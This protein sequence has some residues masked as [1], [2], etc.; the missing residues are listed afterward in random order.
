MTHSLG[1][2]TSAC[3]AQNCNNNGMLSGTCNWVQS[4]SSHK[5]ISRFC[6][7]ANSCPAGQ[8]HIWQAKVADRTRGTRC[9]YCSNRRVCSHNS[10]AT[11]APDVARYWN[12]SKNEK[13]PELVL[14]GSSAK[15]EWKCPACKLEWQAPIMMRTRHRSGCPKCSCA[16]KVIQSQPTFL[17]AQPAYLAE[18]D[19]ELNDADDIYPDNTTLGSGKQVHWICSC[20]PRGQPHRWT[21][22]PGRRIGSGSGCAVCAGMQ[23]CVCNSLESLFPVIAAEFDVDKSGFGP[24]LTSQLGPTKRFGGQVARVAVGSRARVI[25]QICATNFSRSRCS[26]AALS[27]LPLTARN[28]VIESCWHSHA[29][30]LFQIRG[31]MQMSPQLSTYRPGYGSPLFALLGLAVHICNQPEP[32]PCLQSN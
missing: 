14:A 28:S 25:V 26:S 12:H 1:H 16:N 30:T 6:G 17:D 20:C 7:N 2:Q 11:V 10:L 27:E 32:M 29:V 24:S 19:Y 5:A 8:P 18:W 31:S 23:A 22:P 4:G 3:S 13:A 9:P 21:A 15:A